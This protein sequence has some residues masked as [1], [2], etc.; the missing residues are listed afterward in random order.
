MRLNVGV[1]NSSVYACVICCGVS[2]RFLLLV[3]ML[4]VCSRFVVVWL[5]AL[6]LM[7][8]VGGVICSAGW[9]GLNRLL[10]LMSSSKLVIRFFVWDL[11]NRFWFYFLSMLSEWVKGFFC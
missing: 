10:G 4:S 2:R 5:V 1:V 11:D 9:V 8:V 6:R 7:R 3:L